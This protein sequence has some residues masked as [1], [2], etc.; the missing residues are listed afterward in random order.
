MTVAAGHSSATVTR[1]ALSAAS[2]VLATLQQHH[3]SVSVLAAVPDVSRSSFT[4]YLSTTVTAPA[5]L[6]WFVVN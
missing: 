2:L 3:A 1:V 5:K 4:V 6:A